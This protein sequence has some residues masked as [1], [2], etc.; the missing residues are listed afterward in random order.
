M[1]ERNCTDVPGISFRQLPGFIRTITTPAVLFASILISGC[2]PGSQ[3]IGPPFSVDLLPPAIV[4]V[5]TV[6]EYQI[7]FTFDEPV[8]ET[9]FVPSI[10][11]V[12]TMDSISTVGNSLILRFT[13][14]QG[15]GTGYILRME[16]QDSVGNSLEFMYEFSG[17]NP[18][19]PN[20]LINELNPRGSGNTPDCVEI[21]V[22]NEGNL[23]GLQLTVGTSGDYSGVLIFPAVTVNDGDYILVHPK[24]EGIPMELDE[25]DAIDVS[26]GL[27]AV[28]TARDFWIPGSPGLPGNN[29]AVVLYNRKGGSVI[30][31]VIWSDR[32]YVEDEEKLGW[33]SDGLIWASGIAISGG[34]YSSLESGIPTPTDAI[35]VSS[36]TATRSL[37]RMSNPE[38]TDT[39]ADW[40]VVPTSGKTFGTMNNDLIYSP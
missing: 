20:L 1:N 28:D 7:R 31:A 34:W 23:G 32:S 18:N 2:A 14:A 21:L 27:L 37:C 36:S 8:G 12:L 24:S 40:H 17:W 3:T 6:D 5:E 9:G 13:E 30:D 4:S 26:G 39:D 11:P 19:V 35:D 10:E 33:T 16:V 15:I 25:L 38:D 29:G 22:L